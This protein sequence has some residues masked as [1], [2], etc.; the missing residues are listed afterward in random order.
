MISK[1]RTAGKG[2]AAKVASPTTDRRKPLAKHS[3]IS[4]S[5]VRALVAL[6]R[7]RYPQWRSFLDAGFVADEIDPK[8]ATILRAQELLSEGELQELLDQGRTS[9]KNIAEE[10][11]DEF[12]RRLELVGQDNNLLWRRVPGQGDMGILYH[13]ALDK[14]TFCLA[15]FDLLY[16]AGDSPAR[17]ERYLNYVRAHKLPNKWT[18]PTY[19]L[20]VCHPT[21]EFFVKP[22]TMHW[23]LRFLGR[24][25]IWRTVPHAATY[26]AVREITSSLRA[27]LN[28]YQPQDMVDIQSLVW[29]ARAASSQARENSGS[30]ALE[31]TAP[32]E[33]APLDEKPSPYSLVQCATD[34]GLEE[35]MLAQW[36]E[37]IERK[38]QAIIYGPPGTGKTFLANHLARHLASPSPQ[39]NTGG[40]WEVVQFHPAYAYEDFMQGIRP[41]PTKGGAVSYPLVPGRF[42]EFCRRAEQTRGRCVLVI[43]EINRADLSQVLGELMF[44]LEYRDQTIPLA[45]GGLF[46]IPMN[47]RL[48]GTMN[49]ANRSVALLDPALR[50]RFAFLPMQPDY[51]LLRCFHQRSARGEGTNA[52]LVESLID[53]LQ[54]IN[55]EINDPNHA[56]GITYFLV[57]DLAHSLQSIW[58]FE[59]EPYLEEYFFDEAVKVEEFRW[60]K[61]ANM[62]MPAPFLKGRRR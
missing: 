32:T 50:R 26:A 2:K 28:R 6:V 52:K 43:D 9:R 47:V 34:T 11:F 27:A 58:R 20:F 53:L 36:I 51:E 42:L 60:E 46:R 25:E 40:F 15:I 13:E 4:S 19:F 38:G 24:E 30:E 55:R 54:R 12:L 35:Q 45:G 61:V 3:Q 37:A 57:D 7:G 21:T 29:I 1:R 18:F 33:V 62:L 10:R 5:Q 8:Q 44:L 31:V 48:L 39:N 49:T 14:P 56:L 16:G 23:L 22:A 41:Q 59:V 17:L